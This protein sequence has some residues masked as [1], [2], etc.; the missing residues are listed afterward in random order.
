[1]TDVR[2]FPDFLLPG[3]RVTANCLVLS[4]QAAAYTFKEPLNVDEGAFHARI[5]AFR[6]VY[7]L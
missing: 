3:K 2:L 4:C 6:G 1:M 5:T 7:H